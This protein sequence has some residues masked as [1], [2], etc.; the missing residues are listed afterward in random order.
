MST[1]SFC[2]RILPLLLVLFGAAL[3]C[4]L[5]PQAS[6]APLLQPGKKSL[7]QRVISHPGAVLRQDADPALSLIHI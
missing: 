3:C 6:A 1:R 7:Y 5:A 2:R 4:A